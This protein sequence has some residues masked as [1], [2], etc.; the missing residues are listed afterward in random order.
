MLNSDPSYQL[1][2]TEVGKKRSSWREEV[3]SCE[4]PASS[5]IVVGKGKLLS[6]RKGGSQ[7]SGSCIW[8]TSSTLS[9]SHSVPLKTLSLTQDIG[10]SCAFTAVF[11]SCIS[12]KIIF[13]A[14]CSA[15]PALGLKRINV[16]FKSN[17]KEFW[18]SG[19]MP[20]KKAHSH[21]WR[22]RWLWPGSLAD[23]WNGTH[24][25]GLSM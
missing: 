7:F 25:K 11:C 17:T 8:L 12:L 13:W 15:Q 14:R 18:I 19:L 20:S 2:D 3:S 6:A 22:W 24:T 23:L 4:D 9:L 21:G 16:S 5:E 10:Q 1:E